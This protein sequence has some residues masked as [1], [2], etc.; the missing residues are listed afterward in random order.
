MAIQTGYMEYARGGIPM[1]TDGLNSA[2]QFNV[3]DLD[4]VGSHIY[5]NTQLSLAY[6]LTLDYLLAPQ[7]E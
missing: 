6:P 2:L 4:V 1:A 3:W 5:R 7:V